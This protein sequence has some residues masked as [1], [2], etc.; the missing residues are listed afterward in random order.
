MYAF[1]YNLETIFFARIHC[2]HLYNNALH[3]TLSSMHGLYDGST[4]FDTTGTT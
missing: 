4:V 2:G 3:G 1:V